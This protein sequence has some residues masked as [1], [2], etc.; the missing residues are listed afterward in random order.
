M[1]LRCSLHIGSTDQSWHRKNIYN[2]VRYEMIGWNKMFTHCA[3]STLFSP[4]SGFLCQLLG[5]CVITSSHYICITNFGKENCIRMICRVTTV[6][7]LKWLECYF[8]GLLSALQSLVSCVHILSSWTPWFEKLGAVHMNWP[9]VSSEKRWPN[10][11]SM[12]G[13][14]SEL[15]QPW[16]A[17]VT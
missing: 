5:H 13:N 11:S 4:Y 6:Y 15:A 16:A 10:A 12:L 8:S 17:T 1:G 7:F 9:R 3:N 2:Y 14:K